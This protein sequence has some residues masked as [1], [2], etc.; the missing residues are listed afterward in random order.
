[1]YCQKCGKQIDDESVFCQH[2]GAQAGNAASEN[3]ANKTANQSFSV[4]HTEKKTERIK[5]KEE[6]FADYRA[7]HPERVVYMVLFIICVIS[8]SIVFVMNFLEF[9]NHHRDENITGM[10]ISIFIDIGALGFAIA[11]KKCDSLAKT[12][13][14]MYVADI[15]SQ[16][17]SI[18]KI[19]RIFSS[20]Q[21]ICPKCGSSNADN[22]KYCLN[23]SSPK[24]ITF[25]QPK[26]NEWQ[27]PKCGKIN[28]NYVGSCGCGEVKPK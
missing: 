23:C 3:L 4:Q 8:G 7:K 21:W 13:Y 16:P 22:V 25:N 11:T 19:E 9:S 5:S 26:E 15:N 17:N 6:F 2:C 1:M 18:S 14:D 24:V 27:C 20:N 10:V 12:A 28:Q